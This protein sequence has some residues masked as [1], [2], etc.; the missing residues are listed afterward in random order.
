MKNKIKRIAGRKYAVTGIACLIILSLYLLAVIAFQA[1]TGKQEAFAADSQTSEW[2]WDDVGRAQ[3]LGLVVRDGDFRGAITREEFVEI[4]LRFLLYQ[5]DM[6]QPA[7]SG[8]YSAY[9]HQHVPEG[10]KQFTDVRQDSAANIAGTLG[11]VRGDGNGCFRPQDPMTRQEAAVLLM[12]IYQFYSRIQAMDSTTNEEKETENYLFGKY[13]DADTISAWAMDSA[14]QLTRWN[15]IRGVENDCFRPQAAC[16]REQCCAAFLRLSDNAPAS[17]E[18]RNIKPL[19][20]EEE[21]EVYL[22]E[23]DISAL[24][25]CVV[26]LMS[27]GNQGSRVVIYDTETWT[28]RDLLDLPNVTPDN[29]AAVT[30]DGR[31]IAYTTWC[32]SYTCRYLKI[33]D[34][35]NG[36]TTEYFKDLPAR[37]QIIKISWMPDNETLLFVLSDESFGVY[38]EIRS[39]NAADGG[40]KTLVKGGTWK[41]RSLPEDVPEEGIYLKGEG[42]Y[43]SVQEVRAETFRNHLTGEETEIEWAYYLTQGDIDRIY[44]QYGGK[45]SFDISLVP[46]M[47]SVQFAPPRCS[48]DGTKMIYSASL[49][50]SSAPG[51]ETPLWMTSAIWE[52]DFETGEAIVVYTQPDEACIGRVD[53][54]EDGKGVA[55]VSWYEYQGSCDD[56]NYLNLETGKASV[57]FPHTEDHYNNVT[58]LPADAERVTFTSSS[59]YE[60]L[61]DSETYQYDLISGEFQRLDLKYAGEKAIL[62]Q[63][64]Y[65]RMGG[66][67]K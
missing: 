52:Y 49:F 58:L 35:Q 36:E 29:Y 28:C 44:Q 10:W 34:T 22:E 9:I 5:S 51:E 37:N 39:L 62:E 25:D 46:S 14:E 53:W 13:S 61:E 54:M 31:Y 6:Q 12:N 56:I 67:D 16:T 64:V 24:S 3:E 21:Y 30:S 19:L 11:F 15:V 59:R 18:K 65:V 23:S 17:R 7:L 57:I 55:F 38:Q 47:M 32:D 48:P 26:G 66:N 42:R 4:A 20:T 40:E 1:E 41:I 60:A 33:L 50:R 63:F 45:G 8:I 27:D 2:A 43:Q